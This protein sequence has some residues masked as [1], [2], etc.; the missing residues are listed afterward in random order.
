MKVAVLHFGEPWPFGAFLF[1]FLMF[2]LALIGTVTGKAY[3]KGGTVD[4]ATNP[5]GYWLCLV[6]GY[7]GGAFLIFNFWPK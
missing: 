4:R 3:G 5:L 2:L 7:L 6:I 1:G